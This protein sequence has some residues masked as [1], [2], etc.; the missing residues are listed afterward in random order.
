MLLGAMLPAAMTLS[1][2]RVWI[3]CSSYEGFVGLG[4]SHG[5]TAQIY[6]VTDV[7]EPTEDG[8]WDMEQAADGSYTFCNVATGQYLSYTSVRNGNVYKYMTLTGAATTDAE[9]WTLEVQDDGTT[10]V[11][12]V[13]NSAYYWNLRLDGTYLLGAYAGS[14]R[15]NNERFT[16][17]TVAQD[18]ASLLRAWLQKTFPD[19]ISAEAFPTGLEAGQYTE[20]SVASLREAYEIACTLLETGETD[21]QRLADAKAAVE[22]AYAALVMNPERDGTEEA[23]HVWLQDGR[24]E[25]YPLRYIQ[26]Q[27]ENDGQLVIETRVGLT[28]AYPLEQIDSV[29]SGMATDLPTFKTFKFNNKYNYQLPADCTGEVQGDL[30]SITSAGIGKW[31]TPSFSLTDDAAGVWL[32]GEEVFSHSFRRSFAS[33]VTFHVGRYADRILQWTTKADG[34]K[35][36]EMVPMCRSVVVRTTFPT[37]AAA[38]VPAVYITTDDGKNITSKTEYKDAT[39]RID[40]AGIYP[41]LEEMAVQIKGR[42]NSSWST[43]T[44]YNNPKNPYR[45]KFEKKQKPFGMTKGK[46]WVLLANNQSG[47]MLT[48]AIGYRV[49]GMM[50]VAAANHVIP[51]DLYLNGDY[52]G[53]YNFTEKTGFSNNSVDI[54][55]ETNA[56]FLELDSY[57]DETFKFRSSMYSLPVNIK[58]PDF[59]DETLVSPLT[60]QTIADGFNIMESSVYSGS[61]YSQ[62]VDIEMLSRFLAGNDLIYNHELSH[63]KSVFLY[64]EDCNSDES[65][66]VFGPL[67]DCDWAYGYDGS[68][69]YFSVRDTSDFFDT[70]TSG[71]PGTNFFNA[72]RDNERVIGKYYYKVWSDFMAGSLD[73]LVDFVGDYYAFARPSLEKDRTVWND[74]TDYAANADN[75]KKWLRRRAQYVYGSLTPYDTSD[76][77]PA[78]IAAGDVN[79]D[80]LVSAAD[81]VCVVN[82]ILENENETFNFHQADIDDNRLITVA[83]VAGVISLVGEQPEPT[84]AARLRLPEADASMAAGRLE[85]RTGMFSV[86]LEVKIGEGSFAAMQFDVRMPAGYSLTDV[87]PG[88]GLSQMQLH[89]A[90]L[91]DGRYRVLVCSPTAQ[92][93]ASDAVALSL[94]ISADESLAEACHV[95]I[96]NSLLSGTN[97]EEHRLR[98]TSA[99]VTDEVLTSLR[100]LKTVRR[101][102]ADVIFDLGGRR[103]QM[104]SRGVYIRNGKK[105]VR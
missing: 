59:S 61:D 43:P 104:N 100:G 2:E 70:M 50:G 8:L 21:E 82:H 97:G 87:H 62:Y 79:E 91:G 55:D 15:S 5:A 84:A 57:Y 42:G 29:T 54:A 77:E 63:P 14:V 20:E 30:V 47:S 60:Q 45:L 71:R 105:I 35:G 83:D 99:A 53:S 6:Y 92:P 95:N 24:R 88:E 28:A 49:A 81:V 89:T 44:A 4:E 48:N 38:A 27:Y 52:R 39:I 74:R 40:G 101:G 1:A 51:V 19:G 93:I 17:H 75:A 31:L 3:S 32:E 46:S 65:K 94:D 85:V 96:S 16:F 72:L 33:D 11:R 41:D 102:G 90:E 98:A 80:G 26:N 103:T 13:A 25:A 67:W 18:P 76:L 78:T 10:A 34:T 86:P 66:Y 12:S 69:N 9:R 37:D 22:A 7:S 58:E 68:G 23:L 73:E 56:T 64:R 36:Y